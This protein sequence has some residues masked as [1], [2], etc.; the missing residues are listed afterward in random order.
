MRQSRVLTLVLLTLMVW[1]LV[2]ILRI[3]V[4][5]TRRWEPGAAGEYI[6]ASP[7]GG[8]MGVL[9]MLGVLVLLLVLYS[10]V[11]HSEPGPSTWPPE[12]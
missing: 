12:E 9:V 3:G 1:L 11:G 4:D 5:V 7:I 2:T 10:E 8:A 6:G